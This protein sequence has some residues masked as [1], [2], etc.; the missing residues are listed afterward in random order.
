M[1]FLHMEKAFGRFAL[2]NDC[3]HV[4]IDLQQDYDIL[5]LKW[6]TQT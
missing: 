4:P 2:K 6:V 3:H 5:H 1:R